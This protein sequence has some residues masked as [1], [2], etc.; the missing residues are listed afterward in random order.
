MPFLSVNFFLD[1]D[2][3]TYV[4]RR[5]KRRKIKTCIFI[6]FIF[7]LEGTEFLILHQH[8]KTQKHFGS[9]LVSSQSKENFFPVQSGGI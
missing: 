9:L 1:I 3:S 5:Q 7:C 8:S 4:T 2:V 6:Y